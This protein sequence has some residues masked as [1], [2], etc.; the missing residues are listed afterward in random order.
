M[1][2]GHVHH[3]VRS[4]RGQDICTSCGEIVIQPILGWDDERLK[5]ANE[6]QHT[7]VWGPEG[8]EFAPPE[9]PPLPMVLITLYYD[10]PE[11]GYPKAP[12]APYVELIAMREEAMAGSIPEDFWFKLSKRHN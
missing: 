10:G 1:T 4:P 9:L 3:I 2:A 11:Y 7:D 12:I 5:G 6:I 8:Y